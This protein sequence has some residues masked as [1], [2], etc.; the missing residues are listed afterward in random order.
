VFDL[1]LPRVLAALLI[2]NSHLESFYPLRLFAADGLLGD[3][4]FFF[5]SGLGLAL[6]DTRRRTSFPHWYCRRLGRIYP[7]LFL[8]VLVF[9]WLP[10]G[11][12]HTWTFGDYAWKFLAGGSYVFIRQILLMYVAYYSVMRAAGVRGMGNIATACFAI[13]PVWIFAGF[14]GTAFHV[15]HWMFYFQ[16][17]LFGG[18]VARGSEDVVVSGGSGSGGQAWRAAA[19]FAGLAVCYF[20]V[21]ASVLLGHVERAWLLLAYVAIFPLSV[22]IVRVG[23]SARLSK[24]LAQRTRAAAVVGAFSGATLEMYL[25][26]YFALGNPAIRT[27]RFPVNVAAFF[28]LSIVL[29]I[30]LSWVAAKI[31]KVADWR[32]GEPLAV[33]TNPACSVRSPQAARSGTA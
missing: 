5:M 12:W 18:W 30:L 17:M 10:G 9:D 13:Y 29:A 22:S 27:M 25:V 2:A 4:L 14:E 20:G 28:G 23:N 3:S 19:V 6:S 8:A 31:R 7:A 1:R 16:L 15:F 24:W 32:P 21:R 33:E 26:H 11:G